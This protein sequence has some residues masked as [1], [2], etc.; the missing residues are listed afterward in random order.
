LEL[1]FGGE[2][3]LSVELNLQ[4]RSSVEKARDI[5]L[6]SSSLFFLELLGLA[7]FVG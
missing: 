5:M 3:R 2:A 1:P 4:S 7:Y 6:I